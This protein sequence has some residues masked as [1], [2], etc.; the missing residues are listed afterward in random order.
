MTRPRVLVARLDNLGDV[1]L[2][3]PAVRA[4]AAGA[5]VD[6]LAGPHGAA[7]ARLLPGV[8]EVRVFACPWIGADAPPVAAAALDEL[9]AWVRA[10]RYAAAALL[11]SSH[12][13]PLP[14]ALVLR[15]AGVPRLA[16]VSHDYAGSLLDIR[17]KG[18]PDVHEVRRAL[19][20]AEALGFALPPGD[21]GALRVA[22][23]P[24]PAA[25]GA[26]ALG[27]A[28]GSAALGAATRTAAPRAALG[29]VVVHPGASVPARTWSPERWAELVAALV[30]AGRR[31]VVTG[32]AAE[33]G[34]TAAVAGAGA[35]DLGG[36]LDLAGL[37]RTLRAAS[38][39]VTGNT[40]PMHLAAAVGTPVAALF[41]P[42]VDPR[43]WRP[44]AVPHVLLGQLD[45]GCRDCRSRVCPVPDQP[46]LSSV[47][48][49]HVLA[50]V[51]ALADGEATEREAG[52]GELAAAGVER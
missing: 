51:A 13:S 18:D 9:T 31:V 30:R 3:G 2:A 29:A 21:D 24:A 37:A 33:A 32:A 25:V 36:R 23:P 10:R 4:L 43:R 6:F 35:V 49:E 12:Q 19:D 44:W 28:T 27:A 50:A 16:A 34:L 48:V 11:T 26:T 39:V 14:L 38:V 47:R 17:I 45:I 1:L 5:A 40:G 41:A 52:A 15:L 20:V 42:T 7:A 46:C 8:D 22:L